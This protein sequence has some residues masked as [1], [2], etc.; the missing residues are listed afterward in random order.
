MRI[1]VL[2]T[3]IAVL[4]SV[5]VTNVTGVGSARA[6]VACPVTQ[7]LGVPGTH[8]Y[9]VP[10][11]TPW[12]PTLNPNQPGAVISQVADLLGAERAAGRISYEQVNHPADVGV[13]ISYRKSNE[14]AVGLLKNRVKQIAARCPNTRFAIIGYSNGAG[15]AG[16]VAHAIGAGKGPVPAAKLSAVVLFADPRR[17][18]DS[19]TFIGP[20]VEGT[21]VD[22]PRKGGFGA[23][24]DRTYQFCAAG[25][26]VCDNDPKL[27]V[28]RPLMQKFATTANI[29]FLAAVLKAVEENGLD[30]NKWARSVDE[31]DAVSLVTKVATT[32]Q[33]VEAYNRLFPHG[34][35]DKLD[36]NIDGRTATQ[37]A[38]DKI[39][40]PGGVTLP[41]AP[42]LQAVSQDASAP[43]DPTASAGIA[44]FGQ[45]QQ[46]VK[47]ATG[48]ATLRQTLART[49]ATAPGEKL[50]SLV[51][52]AVL[53]RD[54]N[55]VPGTVTKAIAG[56]ADV[57][58]IVL[59][60]NPQQLSR[61][62]SGS[63]QVAAGVGQLASGIPSPGAVIQTVCGTGKA[64][65]SGLAIFSDGLRQ[66]EASA[67]LPQIADILEVLDPNTA[68]GSRVY[69]AL[70]EPIRTPGVKAVMSAMTGIG[71][72]LNGLDKQRIISLARDYA[73]MVASCDLRALIGLP[74]LILRTIPVA[75]ETLSALATGLSGATRTLK[76]A[77]AHA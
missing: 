7:V 75:L 25:D 63:A 22:L 57:A 30:L 39:R 66:Y 44:A 76:T 38:A 74:G 3:A 29:T 62:A 32:V 45:F 31:P 16:D 64:V 46:A 8:Y 26:L 56:L 17:D 77:N 50:T 58:D 53:E 28:L 14:I 5:A 59:A 20:R 43:V 2:T 13:A 10:G 68:D 12:Q 52:K 9:H 27:T 40:D 54:P 19:D 65:A 73:E 48:G 69:A 72:V 11:P 47:T 67:D 1:R 41:I 34:F 55:A 24:K 21:G 42:A 71:K 33:Q 4:L 51:T 49:G 36:L 35:Y 15:V 23:V 37:W 6:D 60:A 18:A 70:P 61:F